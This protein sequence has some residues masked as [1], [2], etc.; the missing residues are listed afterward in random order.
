M[1][2]INVRVNKID[3]H[4]TRAV[5]GGALISKSLGDAFYGF[6]RYEADDPEGN[7]WHFHESLDHVQARGGQVDE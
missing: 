5:A 2:M 3:E 7:Q 4:W 1:A 6:R